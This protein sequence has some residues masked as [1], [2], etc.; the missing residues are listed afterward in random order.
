MFGREVRNYLLDEDKINSYRNF[1]GDSPDTIFREEID[2]A[3]KNTE[4][5]ITDALNRID[6]YFVYDD[7]DGILSIMKKAETSAEL[8][9]WNKLKIIN[10]C[11]AALIELRVFPDQER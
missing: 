5:I 1:F 11:Q 6:K 10:E 9:N 3:A 8:S 4:V 2:E 7:A